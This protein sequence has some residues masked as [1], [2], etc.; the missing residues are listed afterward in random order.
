M[1]T[2]ETAAVLNISEDAVKKR[3]H[4]ARLQ[5][6]ERLSTYFENKDGDQARG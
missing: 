6:R 4:R 3:L 1:R 2:R 5:L